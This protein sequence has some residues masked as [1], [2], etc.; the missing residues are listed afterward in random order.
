MLEIVNPLPLNMGFPPTVVYMYFRTEGGEGEDSRISTKKLLF[1]VV[2]YTNIVKI[3]ALSKSLNDCKTYESFMLKGYEFE[4]V[5][6]A[7]AVQIA[8]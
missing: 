1:F 3:V 4:V 6:F 5:S 2:K 7:G 8:Q